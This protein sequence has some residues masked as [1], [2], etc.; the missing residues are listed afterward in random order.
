MGSSGNLGP[1]DDN[2]IAQHCR[3]NVRIITIIVAGSASHLTQ[4]IGWILK[5]TTQLILLK[6]SPCYCQ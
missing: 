5:C 2:F 4:T 1:M 6:S 3:L